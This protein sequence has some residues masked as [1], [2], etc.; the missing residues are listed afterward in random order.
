MLTL[1]FAS[2]REITFAADASMI[3]SIGSKNHS[4]DLPLAALVST[5]SCGAKLTCPF[6]LVSTKPPL[7]DSAPPIALSVPAT[8]VF[9]CDQIA[10]E[11]AL[12]F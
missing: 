6:E 3:R 4:P 5:L 2:A 1:L 7:P 12:P 11:P 10:I 8:V 9:N